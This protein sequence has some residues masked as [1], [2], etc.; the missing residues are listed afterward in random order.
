MSLDEFI[1]GTEEVRIKLWNEWFL[2]ED[3]ARHITCEGKTHLVEV[4]QL[5]MHIPLNWT[6][7]R[8][9]V[10][11][12]NLTNVALVLANTSNYNHCWLY[13]LALAGEVDPGAVELADQAANVSFELAARWCGATAAGGPHDAGPTRGEEKAQ[14]QAPQKNQEQDED[15][16]GGQDAPLSWE[17]VSLPLPDVL[18]HI[19][20]RYSDGELELNV[21]QI[22]KELPRFEGLKKRAEQN[23]HRSDGLK[24]LDKVLKMSQNKILGVLR[25]LTAA[26]AEVEALQE[27]MAGKA[28][29]E[30]WSDAL[31]LLQQSWA[32]MLDLEDQVLQERKRASIPGSIRRED[33]LFGVEDLKVESER[34][35]INKAGMQVMRTQLSPPLCIFRTTGWT[36][37]K[38]KGGKSWGGRGRGHYGKSYGRF[39]GWSWKGGKNSKGKGKDSCSGGCRATHCGPK[40]TSFGGTHCGPR[41]MR[42]RGSHRGPFNKRCTVYSAKVCPF[43]SGKRKIV[44]RSGTVPTVEGQSGLVEKTCFTPSFRSHIPGYHTRVGPPSPPPLYAEVAPPR[45]G[46]KS[47]KHFVGLRKSRGSGE[48]RG[49]GVPPHQASY[50]MVHHFETRGSVR[51][52]SSHLRLQGP[53]RTFSHYHFQVGPSTKY[54]PLFEKKYVGGKNRSQRCLFSSRFEPRLMALSKDYG[55]DQLWEYRGG[56]FGL[57]VMPQIFMLV[58]KTFEKKWRSKGIMVFIYLDDILVLGSTPRQVEKHLDV[59]VPDLL[60]SGFLINIKK[61]CLTPSQNIQHLGF[62]LDLK[63]GFLKIC[64]QKIKAVKRE[65]GKILTKESMSCRKMAAILGQVRSFLVALP[66]LRAFTD[67]MCRFVNTSQKFGWDYVQGV[68]PL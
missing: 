56:V 47:H 43:V 22:L 39:N 64:P 18:Q 48:G 54:F 67:D 31:T 42:V 60:D 46:G 8:C 62:S 53:Q 63:S 57:N 65:L 16:D 36:G 38:Y 9:A 10:R 3:F 59:V 27:K 13:S 14:A 68:P 44:S 5:G 21:A 19:L 28:E 2:N 25:I 24:Q 4:L 35:K 51:K 58:M 45:R 6:T 29:L 52:T 12:K 11:L 50:T 41:V 66:F 15:M 49:R 1:N 61:S 20:Q 55:G 17:E 26:Y 34:Q 30:D 37:W 32:C 7:T 23:N 33:N 40:C